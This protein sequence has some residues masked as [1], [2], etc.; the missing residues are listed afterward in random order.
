MPRVDLL[1]TSPLAYAAM[2]TLERYLLEST[3]PPKYRE[4]IKIRASMINGCA[5]CIDMHTREAR[6]LGETEH[7][8]YAMAAWRES[9]LFNEEERALLEFT[10]EVTNIREHGVS[11]DVYKNVSWHFSEIQIAEIIMQIVT[12]N[13]WNRI[14]VSTNMVF[15]PKS[16]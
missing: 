2:G 5:Y 8:L 4:I 3:I 1:K 11:E 15:K 7:R 12:I 14:A 16:E 10:E 6:K 13:A 9:P